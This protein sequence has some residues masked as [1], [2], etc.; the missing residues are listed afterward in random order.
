MLHCL[1][2][3]QAPAVPRQL[4]SQTKKEE[5]KNDTGPAV[6]LQCRSEVR[7]N[8]CLFFLSSEKKGDEQNVFAGT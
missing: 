6:E 2:Y 4:S 1:S 8:C 7:E 5:Y 3:G